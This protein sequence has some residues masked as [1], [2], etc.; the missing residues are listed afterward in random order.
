MIHSV[1]Y[2]QLHSVLPSFAGTT[3][4][5]F[6]GYEPKYDEDHISIAASRRRNQARQGQQGL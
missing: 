6:K 3:A 4:L 2:F 1:I 5:I